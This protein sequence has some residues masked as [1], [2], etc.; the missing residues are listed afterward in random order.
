VVAMPRAT[1]VI[2]ADYLRL[3]DLARYLSKAFG[4]VRS[5]EEIHSELLKAFW[6]GRLRVFVGEG[7]SI[8]DRRILLDAVNFNRQHPKFMLVD[9]GSPPPEKITPGPDGVVDIDLRIDIELSS[10]PAAWTDRV[11]DR[12]YSQ[13][14]IGLPAETVNKLKQYK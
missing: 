2:K 3:D 6:L 14:R 11:C 7:G 13:R 5:P 10:D 1:T 9:P 8:A 12:A 4:E